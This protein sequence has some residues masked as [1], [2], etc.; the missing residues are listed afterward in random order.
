MKK[1]TYLVF[2]MTA[3]V[4]CK[5]NYTCSCTS[6]TYQ[7]A[8]DQNGGLEEEVEISSSVTSTPFEAKKKD[9]KTDCESSNAV[10]IQDVDTGSETVK[11]RLQISCNLQ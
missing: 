10:I 2:A 6:K 11:Q 5:K 8:Y 1:L 9:A 4:S 3:L 7:A